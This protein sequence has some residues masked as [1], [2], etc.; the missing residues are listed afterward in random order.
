MDD[1]YLNRARVYL[2]TQD[3]GVAIDD[4]TSAIALNPQSARLYLDRGRVYLLF[5]DPASAIE[6]LEQVLAL[7]QDESLVVPA[8]QLLSLVR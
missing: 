5:D 3:F 7:T 6:D 4:L 8:K 2:E 1:A